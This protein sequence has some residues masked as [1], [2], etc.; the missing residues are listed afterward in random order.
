MRLIDKYK[1]KEILTT[2][3]PLLCH[4]NVWIRNATLHLVSTCYEILPKIELR[5]VLYPMIQPFLRYEVDDLSLNVLKE[6]LKP[7]VCSF[8]SF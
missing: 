4:P 1:L 2:A 6:A 3:L 7:P 8:L 5:I